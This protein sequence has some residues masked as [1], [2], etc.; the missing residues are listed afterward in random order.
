M[1]TDN[2]NNPTDSQTKASNT[3]PVLINEQFVPKLQ[4]K[5]DGG[6]IVEKPSPTPVP[7]RPPPIGFNLTSLINNSTEQP[8]QTNQ[9]IDSPT[10]TLA[11]PP[12]PAVPRKPCQPVQQ[13]PN[14]EPQENATNTLATRNPDKEI[15]LAT[16]VTSL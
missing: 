5:P 6:N 16:E 1:L 14:D 9:Q 8:T 4:A 13:Q 15:K 12:K 10:N 3:T 11:K 7:A 2:G